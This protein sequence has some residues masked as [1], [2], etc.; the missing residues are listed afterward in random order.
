M[1]HQRSGGATV[2]REHYVAAVTQRAKGR[3]E[4]GDVLGIEPATDDTSQARNRKYPWHRHT[5]AALRPVR[6]YDQRLSGCRPKNAEVPAIERKDMPDAFTL[7]QVH[8]ACVG[9]VESLIMKPTQDLAD[10]AGITGFEREQ[11]DDA[12]LNAVQQCG[13]CVRGVTQ[14]VGRLVDDRPAGPQAR[15][16][17]FGIN[18]TSLA[19]RVTI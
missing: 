14:Q 1:L 12:I 3:S 6:Q 19:L 5:V 8:Q 17:S 15:N 9:E 4:P 10:A 16:E 2:A 7:S 11:T 18:A 13:H